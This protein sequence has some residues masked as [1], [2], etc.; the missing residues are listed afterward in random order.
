[1]LEAKTTF[2]GYAMTPQREAIIAHNKQIAV[3]IEEEL[4]EVKGFN[5]VSKGKRFKQKAKFFMK[6]SV[7]HK[8]VA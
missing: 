5:V 8:K 7:G 4:R 2:E 1:M 3:K 6:L